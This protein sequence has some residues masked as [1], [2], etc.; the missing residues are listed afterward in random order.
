MRRTIAEVGEVEPE[1]LSEDAR[2]RLLQ[3]FRSLPRD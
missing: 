2:D 1:S 3:A